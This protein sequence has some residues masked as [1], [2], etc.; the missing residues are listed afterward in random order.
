MDHNL[1]MRWLDQDVVLVSGVQHLLPKKHENILPKF[2]HHDRKRANDH[3][4]KIILEIHLHIV[5]HEDV[6]CQ[7][8]R[9]TFDGKSSTWYFSLQTQTIHSWN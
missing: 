1:N 8:F 6:V 3:I 2:D 5:I 4:K 9:Y 7:F